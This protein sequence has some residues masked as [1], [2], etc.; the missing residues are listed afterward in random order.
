MKKQLLAA[1]IL[2]AVSFGAC[3]AEP[4]YTYVEAGIARTTIDTG[5]NSPSID[6][7]GWAARGSFEFAKDFHVFGGYQQTNND[8]YIDTDV[9]E[10]QIGI[11]WH[12]AIAENADALVEL[13][14]INQQIDASVF[15]YNIDE[16]FDG[17]RASIGFR[18]AFNDVLVA[19][20]KGNYTEMQDGGSEFTPSIGL[21][22][23]FNDTWSVVGEAEAGSGTQRYTLGVRASF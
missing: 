1:A 22:A 20:V 4:N 5:T 9:N 7:D 15:G 12:P 14:Y 11:G 19:S 10:A 3:A 18:G 17:Y 16:D 21:E 13:S 2:A 6:F 8:D 23:R